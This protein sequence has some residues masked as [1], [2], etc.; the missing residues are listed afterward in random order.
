MLCSAAGA[1]RCGRE[2]R[3]RERNALFATHHPDFSLTLR[4]SKGR[5]N[6]KQEQVR[7]PALGG[8]FLIQS[9]G[10]LGLEAEDAIG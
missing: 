2:T 8:R 9:V 7:P 4:V 5:G 1:E 10:A 6:R 3:T